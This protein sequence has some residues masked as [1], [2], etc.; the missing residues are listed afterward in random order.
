[1]KLYP[2][3]PHGAKYN[4]ERGT[5]KEQSKTNRPCW[6]LAPDSQKYSQWFKVLDWFKAVHFVQS[7]TV[8]SHKQHLRD[9][10][11]YPEHIFPCSHM[12]ISMSLLIIN[13]RYYYINHAPSSTT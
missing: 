6:Q 12:R 9:V 3:L 4:K 7:L 8:S 5:M 1:M 11:S 10:N 13:N 2:R